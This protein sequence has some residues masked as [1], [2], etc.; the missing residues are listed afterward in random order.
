[1]TT[2]SSEFSEASK[3]I[4][5]DTKHRNTIQFNIGRYDKAVEKGMARYGNVQLAKEK[6]AA[7]KRDVLA[8]WDKYLL[9]FEENALANGMQVLWAKDSEQATEYLKQILFDNQA[10]LLVKSKSMTTEEIELNEVAESVG[11]ESVETDLGEFIVQV[12]GEKPYHIVTPAMHKSKEDIAKLF[13]EKFNTPPHSTPE[14]LTE[15]VRQLLRKK[16]TAAQVGVTGANF[17]IADIGGVS[18]TENEG[19]ALMTTAFPKLHIVIAGI[20]KI[21]PSFKDLGLFYPLLAAHGTGQQITAYNTIF[22]SARKFN[23]VDGPD[24]M[25]VILLDNNRTEVFADDEAYESLA[26]IRC[27]ACLNGCPVYKTI[28]GYTYNS[29][30]SGPIGSV[31][32]PFLKGFRD[33]SHLSFASTLC[34]KC[35]EVC[36]VKIP[37]TDILLANRRKAVEMNLRPRAEKIAMQGFQFI[38]SERAKFDF[39]NGMVKNLFVSPF[40][41]MGWG[42]HRTMPKFSKLSFS[43]IYEQKNDV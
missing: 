13:N 22:T 35:V 23:E 16:Y 6:A 27:G 3:K 43:K 36:P 39:A 31:L 21:L 30:Y 9:Q 10:R 28:G 4:A 37:L 24:K 33:F 8:H 19:N 1:M 40:N 34:G 2:I 25:I 38:A 7:V 29:T 5:F 15:Y 18:V 12:A 41:W 17:L 14:A 42:P 32:T 26:C 11:C 20:E